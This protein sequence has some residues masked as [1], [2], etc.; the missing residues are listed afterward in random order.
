MSIRST[1]RA[2]REQVRTGTT[3][4]TRKAA[5]SSVS[6]A[7]QKLREQERE[8]THS[9]VRSGV[10]DSISAHFEENGSVSVGV[11]IKRRKAEGGGLAGDSFDHQTV[12]VNEEFARTLHLGDPISI[13]T[14]VG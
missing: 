13:T 4:T 7:A 11:K 8:A 10:V 5:G 1:A 9:Q 12:Q 3:A 2:V 14:V 6:K